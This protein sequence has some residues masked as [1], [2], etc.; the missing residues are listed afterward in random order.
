MFFDFAQL[1]PFWQVLAAGILGALIGLEREFQKKGAG[2]R[3]FALVSLGACFFTTAAV[4]FNS[5]FS[6]FDSLIQIDPARVIQ[7]VA[8]GIG[9]LGSGLIVQHKFQVEGLTTAAAMWAT[10][11][12]GITVGLKLYLLAVLG[13]LLT[14]VVLAGF[15]VLEERMFPED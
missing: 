1:T 9:F 15:R 8:I 11:A 10:A 5:S 4:Y 3:T 2:I 7:A 14:I 6:H 13:T 12:I